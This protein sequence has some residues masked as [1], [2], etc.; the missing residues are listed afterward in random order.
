M[1]N[2][3]R[4]MDDVHIPQRWH[5]GEV[6]ERGGAPVELGSGT[7]IRVAEPLTLEIDLPGKE[8]DFCMTSFAVPVAKKVLGTA[9]VEIAG[10]D[11]QRFPV[12]IDSRQDYEVLNSVRIVKCLDEGRSEFIKWTHRD[13]RPDL[14][15]QYRMVSKLRI[16]L[17]RVPPDSHFF[18]IDGWLIALIVSGELRQE[19]EE[20]GCLG[21]IFQ[22]VT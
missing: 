9:I 18:R 17:G 16:D 19:M 3:F 15:G 11:L 14:A 22:E 6:I 20:A 5:L 21:A 12:I 7:P 13:H 8:L 10:N 2:F 4:L 1:R